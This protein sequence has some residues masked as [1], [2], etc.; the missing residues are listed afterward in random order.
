MVSTSF[1]KR[2]KQYVKRVQELYTRDDIPC[3]SDACVKGCRVCD[4]I[5]SDVRRYVFPDGECIERY[6]DCFEH[7]SFDEDGVIILTSQVNLIGTGKVRLLHR[8]RSLYRDKRRN[9][10]LFDDVHHEELQVS[11]S[12]Q[13]LGSPPCILDMVTATKLP[14][15]LQVHH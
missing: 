14:K 3:G 2:K 10:F 6:L 8:I 5:R 11:I 15:M 12:I 9:V 4:G 7:G 13:R 1:Q